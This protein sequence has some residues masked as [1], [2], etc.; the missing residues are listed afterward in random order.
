VDNQLVDMDGGLNVSAMGM[1]GDLVF[2]AIL[3][4]GFRRVN[5][6]CDISLLFQ[7]CALV[8]FIKQSLSTN[9]ILCQMTAQRPMS[10]AV[11]RIRGQMLI[12]VA[13]KG[14]VY[15]VGESWLVMPLLALILRRSI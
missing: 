7:S 14:K 12:K 4:V 15:S 8:S 1:R 9:Y 11:E 2:W 6:K 5:E 3:R 13:G 10:K